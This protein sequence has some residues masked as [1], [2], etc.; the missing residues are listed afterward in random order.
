MRLP[1]NAPGRHEG[2]EIRV[3]DVKYFTFSD[4]AFSPL[5]LPIHISRA[6]FRVDWNLFSLRSTFLNQ[7]STPNW[8]KPTFQSPWSS[9]SLDKAW[10]HTQSFH[11]VFLPNSKSIEITPSQGQA[12]NDWFHYLLQRPS[13]MAAKAA[14][15]GGGLGI[16]TSGVSHDH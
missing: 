7:G 1:P 9:P 6:T 16:N 11:I 15:S 13:S 2:R 14:L 12:D 8:S 4:Q 10:L 5:K 3:R